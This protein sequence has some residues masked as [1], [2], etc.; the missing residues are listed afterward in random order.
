VLRQGAEPEGLF[1][2]TASGHTSWW[3][4]TGLIAEA[5]NLRDTPIDAIPSS[6]YPTAAARPLNSRLDCSR[7][8]SGYGVQLPRWDEEA[9]RVIAEIAASPPQSR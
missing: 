5:A 6:A 9:R 8:I 3:G 4:F 2:L 1:H 7:I